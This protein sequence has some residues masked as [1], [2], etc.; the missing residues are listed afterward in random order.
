MTLIDIARKGRSQKDSLLKLAT[1]VLVLEDLIREKQDLIREQS[2]I[3]MNDEFIPIVTGFRDSDLVERIQE[4]IAVLANN[5]EELQAI[6]DEIETAFASFK[7]PAMSMKGLD[8]KIDEARDR[9]VSIAKQINRLA[10]KLLTENQALT[11]PELFADVELQTLEGSRGVAITE[12][13]K[14]AQ[15]LIRLKDQLLPLC[16]DGGIIAEAVFHP[17]RAAVS[18]PARISE[19]RSA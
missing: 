16:A 12:G 19:M 13:N 10:R 6:V 7:L 8:E 4:E 5:R 14:E 1:A 11:L 9:A 17:M 2:I 15:R 3:A 18:D